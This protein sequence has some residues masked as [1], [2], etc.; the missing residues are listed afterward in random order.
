MG[1]V[2]YSVLK[3]KIVV[4]HRYTNMYMADMYST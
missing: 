3:T 1:L 4:I 2:L